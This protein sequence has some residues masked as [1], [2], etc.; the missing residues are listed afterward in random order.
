MTNLSKIF[1]QLVRNIS[2]ERC[3]INCVDENSLPSSEYQ[4]IKIRFRT[5]EYTIDKENSEMT[6]ISTTGQ[7]SVLISPKTAQECD[8]WN[9]GVK[10]VLDA[11]SKLSLESD[12]MLESYRKMGY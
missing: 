3:Y 8:D 2:N 12:R 1:Y 9:D 11:V 7:G 5:I 10:V 6:V 4:F